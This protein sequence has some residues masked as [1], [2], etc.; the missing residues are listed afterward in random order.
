MFFENVHN[1]RNGGYQIMKIFAISTNLEETA[2]RSG[3]AGLKLP[4]G[5]FGDD[6][7]FIENLDSIANLLSF[8]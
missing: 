3:Q 5:I 7:A 4:G 2:L 6:F 1:T 8:R